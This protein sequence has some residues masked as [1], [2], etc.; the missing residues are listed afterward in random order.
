MSPN[1]FY[2]DKINTIQAMPNLDGNLCKLCEMEN[3]IIYR[4][5]WYILK[6]HALKKYLTNAGNSVF[7]S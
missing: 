4:M 6:G 5:I 3:R 1:N 2:L 7:T